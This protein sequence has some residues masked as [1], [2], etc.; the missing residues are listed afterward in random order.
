MELTNIHEELFELEKK[1]GKV[2]PKNAPEDPVEEQ[3]EAATEEPVQNETEEVKEEVEKIEITEP[4]EDEASQK[5]EDNLP[6]NDEEQAPVVK[7]EESETREEMEAFI[8]DYEQQVAELEAAVE[9]AAE[10]EEYEEAEQ[11]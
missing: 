6:N 5:S 2:K 7:E 10:N 11:M 9:A 3:E 4:V 1:Y 8:A